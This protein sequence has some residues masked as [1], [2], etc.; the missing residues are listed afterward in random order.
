MDLFGVKSGGSEIRNT[1]KY[2]LLLGGAALLPFMASAVWVQDSIPLSAGWNAVWMPVNPFDGGCNAVFGGGGIDQVTWWNRDR[3]DDGTGSV[4]A[5]SFTWSRETPETSTFGKVLGGECYLVHTLAATNLV[6][7]GT[8]A[9]PKKTV[10]LGE[11][12]LLGMSIPTTGDVSC[13]DYF[14]YFPNLEAT[15]YYAV[16]VENGSVLQN[17]GRAVTNPFQAFWV[18]TTGEGTAAYSG[19]LLVE[20]DSVDKV[21]AWNGTTGTRTIR[22]TNKTGEE[23][24]VRFGLD[25]SLPPP[26][27][28]GT[29]AGD[30]KLKVESIDYSL[31]SA[32]RVYTPISFPFTT[33]LAAGASFELKVRPDLDAMPAA[34]GDYLGIVT[35]SDAGSKI[36][37]EV[38]ANGTCLYRVG[39]MASG[40]LAAP[41]NPE[42]LWVGQVA[43]TGVNRVQMLTAAMAEWNSTNVLDT[44]QAFQFRIIVHVS[45]S[46]EVKLLKEAFVATETAND[47]TARVMADRKTARAWRG[48][49]PKATIRRVSSANFP[50]MAPVAFN[51]PS[52]FMQDGGVMTAS[53]TQ[54]YDAKDNPFVHQFHPN[55]DNLAFNNG[56]PVRKGEGRNGLGDYESWAVTRTVK[57]TFQGTDPTGSN[58]NWNRTVCGGVYEETL[59]GLT[60]E[61]SPLKVQGAFRLMKRL[62]SGE[63]FEN[64]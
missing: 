23:R 1:L 62:D 39:M 54:A 29:K 59:L 34:E 41:A 46:G 7:F 25:A 21:I 64:Q 20:N 3:S 57:L 10:H 14:R 32:R 8:P 11:S 47:A 40:A 58:D 55:H 31:G 44:T 5:D 51:N 19:P 43:L 17:A 50:F 30:I 12:N 63:L 18:K 48:A 16:T 28:Q 61:S 38:R 35:V 33:N 36:N 2:A 53:F 42:G 56:V 45:S 13:H 37:D 27:G 15:P 22:V 49:H 4:S 60:K 9:L 52:S 24:V 6:V 26:A